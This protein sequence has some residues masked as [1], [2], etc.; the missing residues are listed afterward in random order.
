MHIKNDE[1]FHGVILKT[2]VGIVSHCL[3]VLFPFGFIF[4]LTKES[5]ELLVKSRDL[6]D[7]IVK[8]KKGKAIADSETYRYTYKQSIVTNDDPPCKI[9]ADTLSLDGYASNA[10][11]L[12]HK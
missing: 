6:V 4:K 3:F 11:V 9:Y 7:K 10:N 12:P 1:S 8:E 2:Y 5:E